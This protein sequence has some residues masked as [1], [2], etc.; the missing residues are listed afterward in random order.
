MGDPALS[1]ATGRTGGS[2]PVFYYSMPVLGSAFGQTASGFIQ[3]LRGVFVAGFIAGPG[4]FVGQGGTPAQQVVQIVLLKSIGSQWH[5]P[6][7]GQPP[8]SRKGPIPG[9]GGGQGAAIAAAVTRFAALSAAARHAWLA[10]HLAALRAGHI[11]LA[12]LP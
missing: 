11:S 3:N 1:P 12:Q 9:S 10:S 6:G 4:G 5:S 7:P 2:P 8:H